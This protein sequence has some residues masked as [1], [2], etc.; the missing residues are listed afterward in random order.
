MNELEKELNKLLSYAKHNN[1]Y[2]VTINHL[3]EIE[4][5]LKSYDNAKNKN[6]NE[7]WN[8][9]RMMG[10]EIPYFQLPREHYL[11]KDFVNELALLR[12]NTLK[13]LIIREIKNLRT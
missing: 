6:K 13:Q 7:F 8:Q 9:F 2:S 3:S 11:L 1:S 12:A 10:A 5:V 4:Q